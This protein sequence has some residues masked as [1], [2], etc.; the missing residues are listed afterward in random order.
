MVGLRQA[1]WSDEAIVD[2]VGIIA[3]FNFITRVAD[4]L[5]V[6]LNPEYQKAFQ[7]VDYARMAD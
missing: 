5:G 1:G 4:A 7:K 6:E 3:F 2:T